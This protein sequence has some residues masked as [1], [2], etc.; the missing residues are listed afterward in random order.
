MSTDGSNLLWFI[1]TAL[2]IGLVVGAIARLLVP[3]PTPMG[4]LGTAVAGI[5]GALGAGLVGRLIWGPL[6]TPGWLASI[7]GAVVVVYFVS[8]RRRY[9]YDY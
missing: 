3:G 5:A 1:L 4:L 9:Y 2:F 8:R 6:Y 7:L